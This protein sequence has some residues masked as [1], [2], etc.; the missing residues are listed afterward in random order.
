L[1]ITICTPELKYIH[2][3]VVFY[4]SP[5]KKHRRKD[6]PVAISAPR[7]QV[8]VSIQTYLL[9]RTKIFGVIVDSRF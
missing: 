2:V 8:L 7:I 3:F 4:I 1:E 9:K 5:M 6:I